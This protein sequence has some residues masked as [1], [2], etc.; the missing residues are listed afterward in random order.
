MRGGLKK[1]LNE[2]IADIPDEKLTGFPENPGTIWK[3]SELRLDMQGVCVNRS[4]ARYL[5][6]ANL[7]GFR[8]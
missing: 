4:I 1:V 2:F 3:N 6:L 7:N 5:N 8:W